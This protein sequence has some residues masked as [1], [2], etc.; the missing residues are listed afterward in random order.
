MLIV[1]KLIWQIMR[2]PLEFLM[3]GSYNRKIYFNV[4]NPL[5]IM[6]T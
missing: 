2:L 6:R 3:G 4:L 5:V 1:Q